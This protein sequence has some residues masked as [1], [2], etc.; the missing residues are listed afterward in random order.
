MLTIE[1][2][3]HNI[4]RR[5]NNY[6]FVELIAVF[7]NMKTAMLIVVGNIEQYILRKL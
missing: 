5:P 1:S 6:V 2:S 3:S 7:L 4:A